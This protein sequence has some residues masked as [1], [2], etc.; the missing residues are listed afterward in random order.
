MRRFMI[1]LNIVPHA[2]HLGKCK[3]H[4]P[5]QADVL[6]F[7]KLRA[8]HL[9]CRSGGMEGSILGVLLRSEQRVSALVL[10]SWGGHSYN[11]AVRL[12]CLPLH[13][14]H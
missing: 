14:K 6:G 8:L 13:A 3:P 12:L 7:Q 4:F 10:E 2:R 9:A 11:P 5:G 1:T